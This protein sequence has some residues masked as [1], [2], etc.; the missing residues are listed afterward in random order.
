MMSQ[1][2]SQMRYS[3]G[4]DEAA[5]SSHW[6]FSRR[7]MHNGAADANCNQTKDGAAARGRDQNIDGRERGRATKAADENSGNRGE[8]F[9]R[10]PLRWKCLDTLFEPVGRSTSFA[11]M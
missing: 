11:L 6:G 9:L 2:M 1:V 4:V 7:G 10:I 5:L 3:I 8:E